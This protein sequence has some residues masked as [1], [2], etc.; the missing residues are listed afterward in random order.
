VVPETRRHL[1]NC[2][3]ATWVRIGYWNVQENK[4]AA[5]GEALSMRS[6]L[7]VSDD[8]EAGKQ[9]SEAAMANNCI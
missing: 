2:S 4:L 8:S 9:N 7:S 6:A 3:K 1:K 5:V